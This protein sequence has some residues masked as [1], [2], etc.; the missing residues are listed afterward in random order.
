MSDEGE[1]DEGVNAFKELIKLEP[2]EPSH[3]ESLNQLRQRLGLAEEDVELPQL[4]PDMAAL[5]DRFVS[6]PTLKTIAP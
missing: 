2:N 6:E 4:V 3:R 5:V 1:L